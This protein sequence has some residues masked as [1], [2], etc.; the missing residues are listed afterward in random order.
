MK[1]RSANKFDI[2]QI[3]DMLRHYRDSGKIA[4]VEDIE[5]IATPM[6]ILT[7]IL[8]GGGCAIVSEQDMKLT[9]MLLAIK[10]P[11]LW[12]HTKFVMNEVVYWVEESSRGSTAGYR[13]IH[14]YVKQCD[15]LKDSEKIINYT[16]SQMEGQ[17]L[18]YSRFG[19]RPI[20]STWSI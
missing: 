7:Y 16:I 4:G 1:I 10:V 9:G 3:L 20:E 8:V 6:K 13:L 17:T 18:N 2:P 19:F 15:E 12:D 5:D 11:Y 14:E